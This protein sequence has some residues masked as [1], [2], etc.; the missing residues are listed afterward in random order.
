MM[1]REGQPATWTAGLNPSSANHLWPLSS[2]ASEITSAINAQVN[3]VLPTFFPTPDQ[4]LDPTKP[5]I[6]LHVTNLANP[7]STTTLIVPSFPPPN[8]VNLN[9]IMDQAVDGWDGLMRTLESALSGQI[10]AENIPVVG[11]QLKQALSFLQTMDQTVTAQLENDPQ[12]AATDVQNALYDALGPSG[13]NWLVELTTTG[14]TPA[15]DYVEL[16]QTTGNDHYEIQLQ[17]SLASIS[18]SIAANLGLSGLG[19]SVNGN[20]SLNAGFNATLGFGL[21]TTNGFYVDSTDTA[22]IGFTAQLPSI[23]H[24]HA[25]L[26][27]VQR[28]EQHTADTTAIGRP[29]PRPEQCERHRELSLND[30][31][32]TSA[33][34]LNMNADANINLHLDATIAGNTNLPHLSTDFYFNWSPTRPRPTP[35]RSG[36]TTSRST[37]AGSSMESKTRSARCSGRS[38]LLPRYSPPHCRCSASW[39]VTMSISSTWPRPWASAAPARPTSSMRSPRSLTAAV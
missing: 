11:P 37:W 21:S 13:L 20:A 28:L 25:R 38:S 36:S 7:G 22:S 24:R 4:P 1:V 18:T 9:G 31:S 29:E 23:G 3:I 30:L 15:D 5:N 6:E 8:S 14:A 32:S 16:Q 2:A 35:I 26:P 17:K 39:P 10:N 34:T 33:Y 12:I 27:A 19:L